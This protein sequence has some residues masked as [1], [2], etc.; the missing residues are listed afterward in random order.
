MNIE[1]YTDG[2]S[3]LNNKTSGR[4]WVICVDGVQLE[5]GFSCAKEGLTNNQEE[6]KAIIEGLSRINKIFPNLEEI[7]SIT[8]K[9]DSELIINQ[10]TGVY[11]IRKAHLRD[12]AKKVKQLA[13]ETSAQVNF[14]K[15]PRNANKVADTLA[16]RG[17]N[18][19]DLE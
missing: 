9:S 4:G 11:K 12:L 19:A 18:A 7:D 17:L 2:S 1:L 3:N 8:I 14:V 16:K 10:L 5:N 6:Y 15:I 13:N